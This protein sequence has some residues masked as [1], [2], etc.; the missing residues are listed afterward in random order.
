MDPRELVVLDELLA[1]SEDSDT[2]GDDDAMLLQVLLDMVPRD[3]VPR[4]RDYFENVIPEMT[5]EDFRENFRLTR[6]SFQRVLDKLGADP[7]WH[8]A[9]QFGKEAVPLDK[10]LVMTLHFLGTSACTFRSMC[11]LFGVSKSTGHKVVRRTCKALR[12]ISPLVVKWPAVDEVPEI[13]EKFAGL[14]GFP[15]VVGAVDGTHIAIKPSADRQDAYANRLKYHSMLL[16]VICDADMFFL[17][18]YTGWPGSV[19]DAR[20][21]RNCPVYLAANANR[22]A[23]F[24][25]NSLLLGDS[26]YPLKAWCMTPF[27]G[28][29]QPPQNVRYNT[30][31][32]VTR[33]VVERAIGLLKGRWR[34]LQGTLNMTGDEVMVD[35]I[36]ACCVLHNICLSHDDDLDYFIGDPINQAGGG[37]DAAGAG[38][39]GGG[40]DNPGGPADDPA[41]RAVRDNI[42]QVLMAL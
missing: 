26:A 14:A 5:D 33:Q 17:D 32:S 36:L 22:A 9:N 11:N 29:N 30:I 23:V 18:C 37:N 24:P 4:A 2:D 38:G 13:V 7:G 41:A 20:V 21:F 16:Q 6:N 12:R 34:L 39:G 19:H 25:N 27:K 15:N 40:G 1:S 8:E 10:Q 28:P 3:S 35:T 31:H 42:I